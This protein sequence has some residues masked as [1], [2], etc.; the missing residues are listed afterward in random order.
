MQF[1]PITI[2]DKTGQEI[3]LRSAEPADADDL[4]RYLKTTAAETPF[5]VRE[6]DEITLSLRHETEFIRSKLADERELLLIALDHGRHIG[7][8]ALMRIGDC[9]RY[10]HR[11]GIAVALYREFCGRG[12]G[13]AMLETVLAAARSVQYTQA[14]LEVIADNRNAIALYESLGFVRYGILPDNIRYADGSFSDA[15]WM[16][17][18]L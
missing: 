13:R 4:L 17:K 15:Y 8:C 2:T 11:C 18:K 14:E 3:T 1:G 12:I 10:A 7:N 6:P 5:L 9:R 16:M